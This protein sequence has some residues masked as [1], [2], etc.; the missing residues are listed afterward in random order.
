MKCN[1]FIHGNL[2]LL[3]FPSESIYFT[4]VTGNL[5]QVQSDRFSL[6]TQKHHMY[7]T[8]T[9]SVS[10][11]CFTDEEGCRDICPVSCFSG[12][13]SPSSPFS[14]SAAL[15]VIHVHVIINGSIYRLYKQ[16]RS[17]PGCPLIFFSCF[18]HVLTASSHA[19]VRGS[20]ANVRFCRLVA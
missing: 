12:Q 19:A 5:H 7:M 20:E 4:D 9:L 3:S 11:L 17:F 13:K 2:F 6:L 18:F 1:I 16:Q 14:I 8:T 15:C 10:L